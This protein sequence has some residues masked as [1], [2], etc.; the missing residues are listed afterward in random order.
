MKETKI[1]RTA[2]P[3]ELD[4]TQVEE[5]GGGG[6]CSPEELVGLTEALKTAYENLVDFTSHVIER[7]AGGPG[8][9]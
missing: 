3:N 5:V 2:E 9:N 8:T 1:D 6:L 4:A 7:V